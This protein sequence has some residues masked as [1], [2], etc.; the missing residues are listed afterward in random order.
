[1]AE[2][3]GPGQDREAEGERH[4][5]QADAQ[6]IALTTEIGGQHGAAAAAEHEPEGAEQ[7]GSQSLD[8]VEFSFAAGGCHAR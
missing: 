3:V 5:Q 2:R 7:L 8:H 1:M 6:R 4:T